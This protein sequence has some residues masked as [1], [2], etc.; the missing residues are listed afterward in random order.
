MAVRET[1]QVQRERELDHEIEMYRDA[2]SAALDQLEWAIGYL[3]QIRKSQ[4][5]AV[6]DRNRRFIIKNMG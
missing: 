5:A 4:I 6:L 2:A 3:N 1:K